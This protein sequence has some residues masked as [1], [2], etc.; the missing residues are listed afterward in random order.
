M[1]EQAALPYDANV[2]GVEVEVGQSEIDAQHILEYCQALGDANPLY[3]DSA[4]AAAGPHGAIIAPPAF[5]MAI[6]TEQGLDPK[7]NYGNSTFNAGQHCDFLQVVKAGD[8]ITVKSAVHEVYEKTGRSGAML[9]VV[10][11]QTYRNQ[12]GDV[13]ALVDGSQVY[14][15]VTSG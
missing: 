14:R 7:V 15:T 2:L 4:A 8:V 10:R 3:T 9:F 11:R 6:P 1:T 5:I 13:V 12:N